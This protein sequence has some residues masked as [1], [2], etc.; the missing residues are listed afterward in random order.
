MRPPHHLRRM[1]NPR[2]QLRF[3]RF[4]R[5]SP[6]LPTAHLRPVTCAH[7]RW[8]DGS[9]TNSTSTSLHW[10]RHPGQRIVSADVKAAVA[11]R[12]KPAAA[13]STPTTAAAPLVAAG[14]SD[15]GADSE[16]IPLSMMRRATARRLTESA[17]APHF[18]LTNVV[19][20]ERLM[21]FRAE[22]NQRYAERNIKVSVTD[23][24]VR[25]CATTL[26]E[27]PKINASWNQDKI[28]QHRRIHI[29]VAVALDDGLI[30]PSLPMPTPRAWM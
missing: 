19:N 14:V 22:V 17:G 5:P 8:P 25:A 23:L 7:P 12:D 6:R 30:V 10:P 18:F 26:R 27:H 13:Q 16:E 1:P 29:G 9:P 28:L 4:Q 21:S 15:R 11:E 3:R 2:F 24:L 20:I